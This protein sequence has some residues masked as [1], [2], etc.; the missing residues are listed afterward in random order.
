[1]SQSFLIW[2]SI[3]IRR[4]AFK[5]SSG[6]DLQGGECVVNFAHLGGAKCLARH[7]PLKHFFEKFEKGPSTFV[8]SAMRIE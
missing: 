2:E 8:S 6:D 4:G 5:D 3:S 1:M 7:C